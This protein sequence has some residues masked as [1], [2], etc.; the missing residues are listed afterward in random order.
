MKKVFLVIALV[1]VGF[2]AVPQV[3]AQDIQTQIEQI[4]ADLMAGRITPAQA[5]ERILAITGQSGTIGGGSMQGSIGG[6]AASQE[7]NRRVGEQANQQ[8]LQ[9]LQSQPPQQQQSNFP[10]GA[11]T[12]WP[13]AAILSRHNLPALRQPPGT[14][15]SYTIG[16]RDVG[17]D[18][19]NVYVLTI[20][21]K[22][23][24]Q[25]T[26]DELERQ[27]RAGPN[28]N[29]AHKNKDVGEYYQSLPNPSGLN[30]REVTYGVSVRLQDGGVILK[31]SPMY[32]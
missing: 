23:G 21:L 7:Q 22:G 16:G 5:Q 20:Y 18:G 19:D 32:Q 13:T 31:T 14:T 17:A 4:Q 6:D 10:A 25:A 8:A 30:G 29:L 15:V 24:T 3:Q 9:A 12:G 11:T 28:A 27:L 26:V 1:A 2:M